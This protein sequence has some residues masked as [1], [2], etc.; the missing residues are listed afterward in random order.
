MRSALILADAGMTSDAGAMLRMASDFSHEIIAVA[1]GVIEGRMTS[2]QQ[3]FVNEYFAPM[4]STPEDL[5]KRGK[6]HYVSR[7]K[8]FAAHQRIA[9]KTTKQVDLLRQ[10]TRFL[11]YGYDKFVHGSYGSTM[12][13]FTG[14]TNSFMIRGHEGSH[15]IAMTVN[16][17]AGKLVEAL[18]AYGF[19]AACR[20]DETLLRSIRAALDDLNSSGEGTVAHMKSSG[21]HS[22]PRDPQ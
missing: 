4:A 21:G 16:A 1:E 3:D 13:L 10:T 2:S 6:Q 19:I 22:G 12:D 18:V 11:N 7:E 14:R 17:V 15:H 20:R 5:E 8:L 9:E